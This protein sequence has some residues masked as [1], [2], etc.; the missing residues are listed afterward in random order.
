MCS[1]GLSAKRTCLRGWRLRA[2]PRTSPMRFRAVVVSNLTI[3]AE[4]PRHLCNLV[5]ACTGFL[6]LSIRDGCDSSGPRR[7]TGVVCAPMLHMG[8]GLRQCI[9]HGPSIEY[10][11]TY[12][13]LSDLA[14]PG[15]IYGPRVWAP[16]SSHF[17]LAQ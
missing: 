14:P 12:Q 6:R 4:V 15:P 2:R 7:R 1:Q 3:L 17:G 5:G 16:Q 13:R 10:V 8:L 11:R 9:L